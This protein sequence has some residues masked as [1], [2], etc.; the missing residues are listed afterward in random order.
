MTLLTLNEWRLIAGT[1]GHLQRADWL[2][3]SDL[4]IR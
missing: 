1:V 4:L 3:E 2:I